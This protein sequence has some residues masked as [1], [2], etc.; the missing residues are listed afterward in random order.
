MATDSVEHFTSRLFARLEFSYQT[1]TKIAD[2]KEFT[3]AFN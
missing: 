1:W 2:V 3:I